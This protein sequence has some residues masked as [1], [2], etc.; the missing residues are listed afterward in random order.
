MAAGCAAA[1]AARFFRRKA[2]AAQPLNASAWRLS[3][4]PPPGGVGGADGLEVQAS[5]S[6]LLLPSGGLAVPF[7]AAAL[8]ADA[9]QLDL[10]VPAEGAGTP[11]Y[12]AVAARGCGG[13]GGAA[14]EQWVVSDVESFE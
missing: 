14:T 4:A 9:A 10:A 2:L 1:I 13:G 3:W 11:V 12:W 8:A 6:P 7:A 5:F